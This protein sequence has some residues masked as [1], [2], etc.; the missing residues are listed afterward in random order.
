MHFLCRHKVQ[1]GGNSSRRNKHSAWYRIHIQQYVA[2]CVC[3]EI[4]IHNNFQVVLKPW[5]ELPR[6]VNKLLFFLFVI[7]TT[8]LHMWDVHDTGP[9]TNKNL[10]RKVKYI[11]Q[12]SASRPCS[13]EISGAL[14]CPVS[15]LGGRRGNQGL[16]SLLYIEQTGGSVIPTDIF[17]FRECETQQPPPTNGDLTLQMPLGQRER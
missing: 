12:T 1:K 6:K 9:L 2:N 4:F 5:N 17:T 14:T 11:R 16:L 15:F 13:S 7:P 10:V 3:L 8:I